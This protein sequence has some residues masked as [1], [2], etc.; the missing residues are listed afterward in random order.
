MKRAVDRLYEIVSRLNDGSIRVFA[1]ANSLVI[2]LIVFLVLFCF[3]YFGQNDAALKPPDDL[4]GMGG[5]GGGET[6]E[7]ELTLEF[8]LTQG[9]EDPQEEST[10]RSKT[11]HLLQ[12]E[13]IDDNP[14][15]VA[16]PVIKRDPVKSAK[17][18]VRRGNT[19][20]PSP[21]RRIRGSG[22]GSGGNSGGGSGGGIGA[23]KGFSIDWGGTGSRRLL[24][25]KYPVY[26]KDSD[27]EMLVILQFTVLPDGSVSEI[28]PMSRSDQALERAS[29]SALSQWRFEALPPQYGALMQKG[30]IKFNFKFER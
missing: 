14:P 17:K 1:I 30:N 29:I 5:G 12:I 21:V 24:S 23:G 9:A 22:P 15:A 25:G 16:K 4:G 19:P 11:L 27:K 7:R 20:L 13:I 26:P 10:T 2:H 28:H 18:V 3:Q 6:K 8:G